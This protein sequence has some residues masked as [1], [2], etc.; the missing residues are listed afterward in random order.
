MDKK[1]KTGSGGKREGCGRKQMGMTS[2]TFS[3][4]ET[5][6]IILKSFNNNRLKSKAIRFAIRKTYGACLHENTEKRK[7]LVLFCIACKKEITENFD[8]FLN[9]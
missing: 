3:L 2:E 5:E 1:R 4:S 7:S 8:E 9:P 6:K